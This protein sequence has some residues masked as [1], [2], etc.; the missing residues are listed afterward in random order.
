MGPGCFH[1]VEPGKE[2]DN[3]QLCSIG[4][5]VGRT[6]T[7]TC[8]ATDSE[9]HDPVIAISNG[10]TSRGSFVNRRAIKVGPD[11]GFAHE[12]TKEPGL[13][14]FP[15][16]QNVS[17]ESC[18]D[19]YTHVLNESDEVEADGLKLGLETSMPSGK[20]A[21]VH[22]KIIT[23]GPPAPLRRD[24]LVDGTDYR[25]RASAEIDVPDDA[26]RWCR[27]E[28]FRQAS[29]T[30]RRANRQWHNS[31]AELGG[32]RSFGLRRYDDPRPVIKPVFLRQAS[33]QKRD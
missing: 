20:L 24:I 11:A 14:A 19:L 12:R 5:G 30:R 29:L 2:A 32:L 15:V 6:H 17:L 9:S 25:D 18:P 10:F 1:E 31:A 23:M 22:A 13:H 28:S 7:F 27:G 4:I 8:L 21:I 3:L 33:W 26:Y 16:T